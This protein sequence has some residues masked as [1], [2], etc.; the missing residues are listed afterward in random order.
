[1]EPL[2]NKTL[3]RREFFKLGAAGIAVAGAALPLERL[4]QARPAIKASVP[5]ALQLYSVRNDCAKD[6]PGTIA[7]VGKMGY[8]G[9]E[10]AGYYNRSAKE[11][12]KM[13]DDNRLKCCGTHIGLETLLGDNLAKTIEFNQTLGNKFLIVPSLDEERT[14]SRQAW[15]ETARI[16]NELAKKVKPHGVRVGYHNHQIEFKPLDGELPWDTFFGHTKKEVVMQVDIGNALEGGGNP[17]PFLKKYPGRA[18]TVHIKEYSKTKPNAYIGEGDVK[19][20]EVFDLLEKSG[21]T[22]WYIVEYEIEG[23]P[24]LDSVN[25]CLQNLRKMGK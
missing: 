9:V 1:M 18:A 13:L 7:A 3:A 10:F 2:S 6:L 23:M 12:R 22:E 14:K 4:S 5:I 11:L 25:R 19:W 15:L 17:I 20:K 8:S 24:P 16:F 21:G